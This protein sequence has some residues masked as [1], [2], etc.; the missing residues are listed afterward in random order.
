MA[1]KNSSSFKKCKPF[2]YLVN[3]SDF[4]T[5]V[6]SKYS[7]LEHD[8][9]TSMGISSRY[10]TKIQDAKNSIGFMIN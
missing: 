9:D 5:A 1:F 2:H 7:S 10:N 4:P 8:V 6:K 3:Y